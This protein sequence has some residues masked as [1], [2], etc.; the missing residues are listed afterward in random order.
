MDLGALICK[1]VRCLIVLISE[2]QYSLYS[3][4][5]ATPC[6]PPYRSMNPS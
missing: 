4:D 5:R 2:N 6:V 3:L 1:F